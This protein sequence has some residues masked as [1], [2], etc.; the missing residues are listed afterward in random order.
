MAGLEGFTPLQIDLNGD[1][2][3]PEL[4][5]T[6]FGHG[7]MT[8]VTVLADG[9]SGGKPSVAVR[10]KLEDGS[11][12]V[13]ETTWNLLY[14]SARAIEA[15]YGGAKV[16]NAATGDDLRTVAADARNALAAIVVM[17][18]TGTGDPMGTARKHF[19]ALDE[20]LGGDPDA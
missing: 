7:L 18:G 6:D 12:V 13:L 2:A 20:V 14:S 11:E 17:L 1:T 5:G 9:T 15:R 3:W 8:H 4:Q 19:H 16:S 10:G